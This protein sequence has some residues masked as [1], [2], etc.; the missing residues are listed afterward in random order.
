MISICLVIFW[1]EKRLWWWGVRGEKEVW[2]IEEEEVEIGEKEVRDKGIV[3]DGEG[4][5]EE[6]WD[7]V[8]DLLVEKCCW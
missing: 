1:L 6:N 2:E 8:D 7:D 3:I 5:D 4:R